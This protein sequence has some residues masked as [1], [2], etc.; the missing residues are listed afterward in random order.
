MD[1][2]TCQL[3]YYLRYVTSIDLSMEFPFHHF[4]GNAQVVNKMGNSER[5]LDLK[6]R[7]VALSEWFQRILIMY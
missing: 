5:F 7:N 2:E 4:I 3:K 1:R 6:I